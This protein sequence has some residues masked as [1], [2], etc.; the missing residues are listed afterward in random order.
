MSGCFAAP[1][2]SGRDRG[3]CASAGDFREATPWLALVLGVL[4]FRRRRR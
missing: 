1:D 2:S 3:G 4:V